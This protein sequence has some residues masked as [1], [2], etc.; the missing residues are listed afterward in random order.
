MKNI[1]AFNSTA[2]GESHK[3]TKKVCQ[4][5][6]ACFEDLEKGLFICSVSDGHGGDMYFRSDRGSKLLV[7]ITI[8]AIQQFVGSSDNNLFAVPFTSITALTTEI[9]EK[10]NRKVTNQDDAIRRLFSSIISQW[11]DGITKDW[12]EDIPSTEEM[13][14]AKVPESTIK[15]FIEG[16]GIEFAYGC[17]LIAFARTPEYWFAFQLGDGKCIA[18][19]NDAIWN[20]P[21]PWDEQCS[22]ST[23]TSTCEN[24]PL[25]NLR[26]CYGNTNFP[27]ALFIG[28]DG[29]DGAYGNIEDLALLYTEIVKSFGKIGFEKTVQEIKDS[30]PI[31]SAKGISRDD[32]SLAGVIDLDELQKLPPLLKKKDFERAKKDYELAEDNYTKK[33]DDVLEKD[34]EI[35]QKGVKIIDLENTINEQKEIISR[36]NTVLDNAKADLKRNEIEFQRAE[37]DYKYASSG[38]EKAEKEKEA[39][40][41]RLESLSIEFV[42]TNK[43]E[44]INQESTSEMNDSILKNE[45]TDE[46]KVGVISAIMGGLG[47]F[48]KS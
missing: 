29:M 45:H 42:E 25:E 19:D 36:A 3:A 40:Q 17:T 33:K 28:S 24:N 1:R 23:T 38:I 21:I 34:A 12:S 27:V 20:E 47:S 26:Y 44:L 18:F 43:E 14:N 2:L 31:L 32:M 48:F 30:L 4:D 10:I 6:S 37:E 15:S 46:K 16:N 41:K 9:K 5:S 13:Q 35:K 7:K 22:G 8:D 11:N 39:A